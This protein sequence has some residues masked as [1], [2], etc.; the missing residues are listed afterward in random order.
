[1]R[2]ITVSLIFMCT[3]SIFT[4]GNNK[5]VAAE[6]RLKKTLVSVDIE[7]PALESTVS[8]PSKDFP[9]G[10]FTVKDVS[11]LQGKD[12][13]IHGWTEEEVL[14]NTGIKKAFNYGNGCFGIP[15][16]SR[17]I[18]VIICRVEFTNGRPAW[19]MGKNKKLVVKNINGKKFSVSKE[20]FGN[21]VESYEDYVQIHV[22]NPKQNPAPKKLKISFIESL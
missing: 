22:I 9:G 11:Y 1:M 2:Y 6:T 17:F 15:E 16:G 21:A 3:I 7:M 5:E 4:I 10:V 8:G 12:S 20:S 14:K 18:L 13:L 19:E